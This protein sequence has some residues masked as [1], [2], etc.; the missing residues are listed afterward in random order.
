MSH[1][2]NWCVK[3]RFV[4]LGAWILALI[5]LAAAV[6]TAGT[7]FT[8]ATELPDS[9]SS[10]A[11][12]LMAQAGIGGD[13]DTTSGNIVWHTDG[14]AINDP[15]VTAQ[16]TDVLA[17]IAAVPGVE[18]VTSPYDASGAQQLNA[19]ANTAFATVV[20]TDDADHAAIREVLHS[21]D[22]A[23][24]ETAAGGQGFTEQPEAGGVMEGMG[25]IAALVILLLVFRSVWAAA[26]PI[27]TGVTGVGVSLLG[28]MMISHIL[29]LSST[30]ITMGSLIGLGVGIDYA[31]FIVN[32]YRKAVMSGSS[33]K[34]AI[35]ESMN[36][37]G[38]AVIFAG[39]TVIGALLGIFVVGLGVLTGMGQAAAL[40]VLATVLAAI[41][42]LPALLSMLG[43]K[44]LSKKQRAA[45]AAGELEVT[46]GKPTV[47]SKW[48]LVSQRF[49]VRV[50]ALALLVLVALASPVLS[51]RVG[52]SDA[53]SDPSGSESNNYYSMMTPAFGAGVDST[54]VLV[55]QT[56]DDASAQA[57][58]AL[59]ADLASVQDVSAV[60]AAPVQP[61]QTIAIASVTPSSSA[62]TVETQDLVHNLRDTVIPE[63]SAGTDL[64]VYVGGETATNIDI[65]DALMSKLP[66]Y[67]GLVAIFGFL[68]LAM[69]FRSI[70]VPLV[71]A[72]SN[73][74]TIA[75][76]LGVITAIFQ[77]GWGSSLLGVGSGAPVT[78]IVPIIIV[79]VMFGLSM[80]YQVFLVSRMH[81]EWE[82]TH[83][84]KRA[85]RVGVS[86]TGRVIATA[87]SIMLCV[88]ASFGFSGERIVSSI[89]I[90]L[91]IA[92]VIDAFVV[93]LTLV[94]AIMQLIGRSNWMYPRWADRIT[95]HLSVEGASVSE[96]DVEVPELE[97]AGAGAGGTTLMERDS[98]SGSTK[99]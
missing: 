94:P 95:P 55:A 28:V 82:Q 1:L 52:D 60:Q 71:G 64:Q 8:D 5:A 69:A 65:S 85:V 98:A 44:V 33:V 90:G 43:L 19:Q 6:L 57:F 76:G 51:I 3:R 68:L 27:I 91:A 59:V 7:G 93:R 11:Y 22:S 39:L 99:E 96:A 20:M 9:E 10:T 54:L 35:S 14:V 56:P 31:L 36:T 92:V 40:T 21:A 97:M 42:L 25:V 79:G 49:P 74:M 66:L 70:L 75:V 18:Q 73:I 62:Q 80:D 58:T 26:L 88:F 17:Q 53:S 37:S 89:G 23:S 15:A 30:S 24:L 16:M 41:T 13:A 67:L 29:D 47:W 4:V 78:Y 46:G 81:E 63:A 50:G 45:L 86:E 77:F 87:A 32:R 34:E 48:A 84:N 38:R 83:D 2:A 72:L 12:S 61:G